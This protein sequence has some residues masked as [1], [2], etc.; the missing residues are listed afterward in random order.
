MPTREKGIRLV[1]ARAIHETQRRRNDGAN[2]KDRSKRGKTV[3]RKNGVKDMKQINSAKS[4]SNYR[5]S[6]LSKQ[7][8]ISNLR[9]S[10]LNYRGANLIPAEIVNLCELAAALKN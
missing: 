3:H 7:R 1:T 8:R 4:N 2:G 6:N 10:G 5:G 9:A